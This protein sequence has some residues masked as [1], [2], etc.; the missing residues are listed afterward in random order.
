MGIINW[1]VFDDLID[2]VLLIISEEHKETMSQCCDIEDV[3]ISIRDEIGR[4]KIDFVK[5]I[6]LA[7]AGEEMRAEQ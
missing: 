1:T 3:R 5:I 2:E 4:K 6:A 7:L